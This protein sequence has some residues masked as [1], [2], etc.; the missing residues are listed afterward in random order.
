[1][2]YR[3]A[4]SGGSRWFMILS[5]LAM[6]LAVV[7]VGREVMKSR[8]AATATATSANTSIAEPTSTGFVDA[9]EN[10]PIVNEDEDAASPPPSQPGSGAAPGAAGTDPNAVRNQ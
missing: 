1:M 5:L 8:A 4:P 10:S 9:T 6:A 3:E 2:A 7:F